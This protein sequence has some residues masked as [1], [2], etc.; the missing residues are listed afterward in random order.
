MIA[1]SFGDGLTFGSIRA[2]HPPNQ[3]FPM[4]RHIVFFTAKSPDKI[5]AICDGLSLLAEIP[6]SLKFEISRNSRVDLYGNEVD[7]VVYGEFADRAALDAYKAH[8]NYD[9]ATS[10]VRP[11]RDMRYAADI[12]VPE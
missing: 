10:L 11:M 4:I 2:R 9:K 8:P 7:V 12:V 1:I 3:S 6:H 5:D